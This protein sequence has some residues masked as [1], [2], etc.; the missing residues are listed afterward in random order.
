MYVCW[1]KNMSTYFLTLFHQEVES[2]SPSLEHELLLA[3]HFYWEECNRAG[4]KRWLSCSIETCIFEGLTYSIKS[5]TALK[6]PCR[7]DHFKR[8]HKERC[9]RSQL[10][11]IS[12]L[13]AIQAQEPNKWVSKSQTIPVPATIWSHPRD[14]SHSARTI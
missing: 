10:F 7:R 8:L 2:K 1:S 9:P 11:R 3:T 4:H 14:K 6:L 12:A 5:L 13:W